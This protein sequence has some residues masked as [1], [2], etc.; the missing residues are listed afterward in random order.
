[1]AALVIPVRA[2]APSL[3]VTFAT[4]APDDSGVAHVLE[5]LVFRGARAFP[6][7]RLYPAMRAGSLGRHINATTGAEAT[8]YHI[9]TATPADLL[10]LAQVLGA[11]L[12]QPLLPAAAFG[13][14]VHTAQSDGIIIHEMQGHFARP[15]ARIEQNLRR[16]LHGETPA[17]RAYGGLPKALARLTLED[18]RAYHAAHYRP[19]RALVLIGGMD[20]QWA[21]PAAGPDT[22]PDKNGAPFEGVIDQRAAFIPL[23]SDSPLR[24]QCLDALGWSGQ[25][26]LQDQAVAS[27]PVSPRYARVAGGE[28]WI[29]PPASDLLRALAADL[30][31]LHAPAAAGSGLVADSATPYFLRFAQT[32]ADLGPLIAALDAAMVTRLLLRRAAHHMDDGRDTRLPAAFLDRAQ[33]IGRWLQ[34][35]SLVPAQKAP[36]PAD[37]CAAL[38]ELLQQMAALQAQSPALCEPQIDFTMP[39]TRRA[40]TA[41]EV[42][43]RDVPKSDAATALPPLD[44][45][46]LMQ[47]PPLTRPALHSLRGAGNADRGDRIAQYHLAFDCDDLAA[48]ELAALGAALPQLAGAADGWPHRIGLGIGDRGYLSLALTCRGADLSPLLQRMAAVLERALPQG[49]APAA[50]PLH[51][52]MERRLRAGFC[53]NWARIDQ[54]AG[55]GIASDVPPRPPQVIARARGWIAGTDDTIP[56]APEGTLRGP[57]LTPPLAPREEVFCRQA[58]LYHQG[59]ALHLPALARVHLAVAL[60]AIESGWLWPRLRDGGGA[61]GLRTGLHTAPNG[62]IATMWSARDPH[63]AQSL[64]TMRESGR[65]LARHADHQLLES[66]KLPVLGAILA[67]PTRAE[68]LEQA[69]LPQVWSE[70]DLRLLHAMTPDHLIAAGQAIDAAM[71]QGKSVIIADAQGLKQAGLAATH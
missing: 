68:A 36:A 55:L 61:Y 22:A 30:I 42:E 62:H 43:K 37:L 10:R 49:A 52:A 31:L 59:L 66:A 23:A 13:D 41:A 15:H 5:H 34:G 56:L 60:T 6:L 69:F 16:A 46:G 26:N 18:V 24:R 47:M 27:P 45:T 11:A 71:A 14:E 2:A 64:A 65:W 63:C 4:P 9:E 38:R 7:D 29:F 33:I 53:S 20:G 28:G 1:M 54:M 21:F 58:P 67:R 32:P 25:E 44:V 51:L 17:G 39:R 19:A 40:L 57:V 50:P 70:A 3:S 8:S 35:Q 12:S 48:P